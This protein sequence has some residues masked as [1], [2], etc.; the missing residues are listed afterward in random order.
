LDALAFQ[1][2]DK[3]RFEILIANPNSSDNIQN[4]IEHYQAKYPELLLKIINFAPSVGLD[5]GRMYNELAWEAKGETICL[6]DADAV[7]PGETLQKIDETI[8][9]YPRF[10]H[11]CYR[12]DVPIE[13]VNRFLSG[14]LKI[15]SHLNVLSSA[16]KPAH[17]SSWSAF[18][19]KIGFFQ[20]VDRD[21]FLEVNY[22]EGVHSVAQT[23]IKFADRYIQYVGDNRPDY[24]IPGLEIF[25][26]DHRRSWEGVQEPQ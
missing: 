3:S 5:R 20:I 18:C 22:E 16:A 12:R 21:T 26:L 15:E 4:V 1:S 8:A 9:Q 25:H 14:E 6:L 10:F 17:L 19:G 24:R 2:F 13:I 7:L 23:D 11:S